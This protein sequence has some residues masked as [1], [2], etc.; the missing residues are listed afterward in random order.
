MTFVS[1]IS[2]TVML[3]GINRTL[4]HIIKGRFLPFSANQIYK[5]VTLYQDS[6]E[7]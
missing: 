6:R 1:S 5:I 3:L 2:S 7:N 4:H